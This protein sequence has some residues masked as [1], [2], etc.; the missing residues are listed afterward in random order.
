M[1]LTADKGILVVVMDKDTYIEKYMPLLNDHKVYQEC[2]AV[3]KTI[4]AIKNLLTYKQFRSRVQTLILKTVPP[5][6]N[7]LPATFYG[8]PKA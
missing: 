7:S 1:V 3:T 2:R 4:H 8:I 6:D 5:G